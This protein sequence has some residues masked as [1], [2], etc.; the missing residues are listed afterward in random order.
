M[1]GPAPFTPGTCRALVLVFGPQVVVCHHCRKFVAM[2]K[3]DVPYDPC[4]FR[5]RD[6]GERGEIKDRAEAAV[7]RRRFGQWHLRCLQ[8]V[9]DA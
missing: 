3:H 4:P 5:C 9:E 1:V 8:R 2:P 7:S 6:C